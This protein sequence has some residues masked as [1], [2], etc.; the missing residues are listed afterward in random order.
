MSHKHPLLWFARA[1]GVCLVRPL[2]RKFTCI[3]LPFYIRQTAFF[4]SPTGNL[5]PVVAIT[6]YVS[7]SP[8]FP[9]AGKV[10][11]RAVFDIRRKGNP[12][13]IGFWRKLPKRRLRQIQRGGFE[14][15]SRFSRHNVAGNRDTTVCASAYFLLLLAK[16]MPSETQKKNATLQRQNASQTRQKARFPHRKRALQQLLFS[17]WY[18]SPPG[19]WDR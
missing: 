9:V 16:S 14:E 8:L 4:L 13:T 19:T 1:A 5:L 3:P 15:V 6:I 12:K 10:G 17:S 2:L 11:K 18:G 7:D